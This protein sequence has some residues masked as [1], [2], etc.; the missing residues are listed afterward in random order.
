MSAVQAAVLFIGG[1]CAKCD[2][3]SSFP[4]EMLG[5]E[6]LCQFRDSQKERTRR[7]AAMA[8]LMANFT[9]LHYT[10]IHCQPFMNGRGLLP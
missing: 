10:S 7:R 8:R 5:C 1:G 4:V 6:D 9:E 2:S 3:V